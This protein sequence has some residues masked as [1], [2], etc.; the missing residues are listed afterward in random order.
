VNLS[1][2]LKRK[3]TAGWA[4]TT[5][6]L[7]LFVG[8]TNIASA[9]AKCPDVPNPVV[10]LEFGSR[11]KADSNTRSDIDAESDAE[12]TSVLKSI[13]RFI[14]GL[15]RQIG[16]AQAEDDQKKQLIM[17]S[18]V[19]NAI[20]AWA[21]AD[22]L[23]D[24]RTANAKLAVPSRIGGIA[25]AYAETRSMVPGMEAEKQAIETWLLAR[26]KATM[27]FFDNDATKGASR[28]NLRAWAS[29]GVGQIGILSK[30]TELVDW[31]IDSNRTMV[32]GSAADGSIPLEMRR[33]KY[34]LHYQLHALTPLVT[35][36]AMICDAG[37]GNGQA[38]LERLKI[39]AGF[40]LN[41]VKNP[42]IVEAIA[43]EAQTVEPGLK[44]NT[45]SLAWLEP[46]ASLT[47]EKDVN[48]VLLEIRPLLNSKLGGDVTRIYGNRHID[49]ETR[50]IR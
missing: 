43:G 31:S 34:A 20:H 48:A 21:K 50:T 35:S 49:C 38:D 13:D 47:G 24:M 41:G 46:Y 12:V 4:V 6:A 17:S 19:L 44:A 45:E 23:S 14:Q 16:K 28:N 25:I 29:L 8:M 30:Q 26:A 3:W 18:C 42:K 22:A 5:G 40:S 7:V 10:S 39:I 2:F 11:Y 15:T 9:K 27:D 32:T 33:K 36:I 1:D 37:Y